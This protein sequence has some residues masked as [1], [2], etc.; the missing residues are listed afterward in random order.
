MK[1][2]QKEKKSREKK[3]ATSSGAFADFRQSSGFREAGSSFKIVCVMAEL[4]R[5]G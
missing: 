1:D 4:L 2:Q 3:P 5:D